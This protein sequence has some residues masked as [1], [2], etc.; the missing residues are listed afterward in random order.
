MFFTPWLR[1]VSRQIRLPQFRRQ[2]RLSPKQHE[3]LLHGPIVV[4]PRVEGLEERFVLT[5]PG[6]VSVTPNGGVF[7][8]DGTTL[9]ERP[10]ELLFQF[11]PGQT[12]QTSTLG[13]IQI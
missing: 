3:H 8:A 13:A 7:L 5:P 4:S 10:N 11:S 9:T 6:F 2:Q 12:L 1:S